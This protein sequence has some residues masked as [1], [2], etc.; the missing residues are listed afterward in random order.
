[1]T[2]IL[3]LEPFNCT[4]NVIYSLVSNC[5]RP[6]EALKSLIEKGA[7]VNAVDRDHRTA[8]D[9]ALGAS[10]SEGKIQSHEKF[11]EISF[12]FYG[13]MLNFLIHLRY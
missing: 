7:N 8:L 13:R 10:Q 11:I 6:D 3:L 1:M 9:I 2:K 12:H 4:E 5:E